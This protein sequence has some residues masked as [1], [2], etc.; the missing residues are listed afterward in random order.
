MALRREEVIGGVYSWHPERRKDKV[1][2]EEHQHP[3]Q[4]LASSTVLLLLLSEICASLL[5]S[6]S[7][8]RTLRYADI[9]SRNLPQPMKFQSELRPRF[10]L[11]KL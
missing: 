4:M 2:T 7:M 10:L 3:F 1:I 8:I 6:Q 5:K 9:I 11:T